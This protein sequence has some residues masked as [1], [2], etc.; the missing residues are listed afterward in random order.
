M[1][2]KLNKGTL[3]AWGKKIRAEV[4]AYFKKQFKEDVVIGDYSM[5]NCI[6]ALISEVQNEDLVKVPKLDEVKR[7]F[8][9]QR[10]VT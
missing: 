2:S 6:P 3:S 8:L 4:V 7:F 1:K 9:L 10:L 5:L